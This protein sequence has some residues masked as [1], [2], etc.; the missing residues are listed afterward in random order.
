M[1]VMGHHSNVILTYAAVVI[2]SSRLRVSNVFEVLQTSQL[3]EP[4]CS[5][6]HSFQT[7]LSFSKTLY[8]FCS[9]RQ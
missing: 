7:L 6:E 1:A 5:M 8:T 3:T 4:E 2:F 9:R